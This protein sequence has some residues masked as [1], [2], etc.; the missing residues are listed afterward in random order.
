MV[1]VRNRFDIAGRA[2]ALALAV[3]GMAEVWA[4]AF[5]QGSFAVSQ[6]GE[7][8]AFYVQIAH[9]MASGYGITFDRI[10]PTTGVHWG[11]LFLLA[12]I[13]RIIP[14]DDPE[15]LFRISGIAYFLLLL[16]AGSLVALRHPVAGVFL[17]G[18]LANRGHWQLET[19]LLLLVMVMTYQWPTAI[20]GFL[21]V[22]A[23]SDMV[24]WAAAFSL[25]SRQWAVSAG[26]IVGFCWVCIMNLMVDGSPISISAHIKAS[27][28]FNDW[29]TIYRTAGHLAIYYYPALEVMV[30]LALVYVAR[31]CKCDI[32]TA[33]FIASTVLLAVHV[34]RDSFVVGWYLAPLFLSSLL[35]SAVVMRQ[36]MG[37]MEMNGHTRALSR[38]SNGR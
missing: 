9:N 29:D 14:T 7:D 23:R 6:A 21:L 22:F 31:V 12:G 10:V 19:N 38:I 27:G 20:C 26:A 3:I 25:L 34:V 28:G 5:G 11:W 2:G 35:C 18:Y 37:F 16:G 32:L 4:I 17:V 36:F 33:G 30:V 13:F 24:I 1:G 15:L 8:G